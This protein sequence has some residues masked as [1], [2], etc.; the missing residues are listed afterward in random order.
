MAG[1]MFRTRFK[2]SSALCASAAEKLTNAVSEIERQ[3]LIAVAKA[4]SL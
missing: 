1:S 3:S 4:F 2:H